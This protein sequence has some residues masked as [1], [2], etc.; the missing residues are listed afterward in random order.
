MAVKHAK[1]LIQDS[2]GPNGTLNTD[3]MARALLA[4]RNTPDSMT[5]LSPAQV[6]F[7]RAIRDFLPASP[8]RYL[9]RAEWRLTA[10]NRE[11]ALA[12]RHVKLEESLVAK[13]RKLPDL[14]V[15][16][17]VSVQDQVGHTP[18]QWSKTGTVVEKSGHDSYLVKMDGSNRLSKRNR[19]FIRRVTPYKCD[20]D[21]IG[22]IPAPSVIPTPLMHPIHWK[23]SLLLSNLQN[24]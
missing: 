19:Q 16:D 6:I 2:L 13:S 22:D 1:R 21:K 17:T 14:S 15:G 7:G 9:P 11:I 4:H 23:L 18:R 8:G 3:H 10:N 12:K 20:V 5:G 24:L